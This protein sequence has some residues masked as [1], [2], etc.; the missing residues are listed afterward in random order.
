MIILV[1]P[2]PVY[3]VVEYGLTDSDLEEGNFVE[4]DSDSNIK[5]QLNSES[6]E[7][8]SSS[9]LLKRESVELVEFSDDDWINKWEQDLE[10]DPWWN[11]SD[12][13]YNLESDDE[14]HG[15]KDTRAAVNELG[16]PSDNEQGKD[17]TDFS[18]M[19]SNQDEQ[20]KDENKYLDSFLDG[21]GSGDQ[22]SASEPQ[23][24]LDP[25]IDNCGIW[26]KCQIEFL[27]SYE[28]FVN[29]LPRCPCYYPMGLKYFSEVWDNVSE[30]YIRWKDIDGKNERIDV[31]KPDAVNCIRSE[32]P[33][34]SVL[35]AQ[36]C[37]YDTWM[38]LITRGR[39][40]GTLNLVSPDISYTLH[41]KMDIQPWVVCK[42]NWSKY[43]LGRPT[44]K[45]NNCLPNPEDTE[46][47]KQFKEL[48]YR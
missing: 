32:S 29:A 26:V 45:Q 11:E 30:R 9:D 22:G 44:D 14:E 25:E 40:A 12:Y 27:K 28:S 33:G 41:Q 24:F 37:C 35:S 19:E 48:M 23:A 46:F 43:Q 15:V 39:G 36:V 3:E 42:G 5:K 31:Y 13:D 6:T 8:N 7:Y 1:S 47:K 21:S 18:P 16:L 34:S 17:A 4:V 2:F 20:K 10:N 38:M